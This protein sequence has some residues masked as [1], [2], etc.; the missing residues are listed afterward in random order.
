[1]ESW[2][3]WTSEAWELISSLKL[4]KGLEQ[5]NDIQT[6]SF[7]SSTHYS[8][9]KKNKKREKRLWRLVLMLHCV[10]WNNGLKYQ[11]H[12]P[13]VLVGPISRMNFTSL[14]QAFAYF[15]CVSHEWR[16]QHLKLAW[17][18]IIHW[19]NCTQSSMFMHRRSCTKGPDLVLSKIW[20]VRIK[21]IPHH[22]MCHHH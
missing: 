10:A 7:E 22:T 19:G 4:I 9:L 12:Y 20:L 2:R 14:H 17:I 18:E 11:Y 13:K 21:D 1:M 5:C 15:L 8:W 6:H 3:I 16:R